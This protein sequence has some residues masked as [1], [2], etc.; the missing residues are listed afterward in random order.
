MLN[1]KTGII[2]ATLSLLV[3]HAVL[4][5]KKPPA[6]PPAGGAEPGSDI[7]LERVPFMSPEQ[8]MANTE[9]MKGFRL[10]LVAAEPQVIDPVAM[11]FDEA[12]RLFVVEMIDY[13]EQ[14]K[15]RL[16]R[17]RL[18]SDEDGDGR[19]EI[20]KIFVEDL[21]WPTAIACYD[22]GIFIGDAPDIL[23]C[24]D[25]DGDG[26]AD[27]RKV[28]FTGFGRTNVQGLLNTFLWGLDHK[29]YGQTSGSGGKVTRPGDKSP[30]LDL[31]DR[32]FCFDPKTLEI[33]AITGGG[34]HGMSFNRWGDR[35]VCQNSDHLQAIVFEERYMARNPYQSVVAARRSIATDGPQAP[36]F[37]IS[38]VEAWRIARTNLRV[39]GL[40]PGPIEGGGRAAGYF[41]GSTGV[42]VYEG[43]LWPNNDDA[44]VLISDVGSN[45]IHRKRLSRDG[46]TYRGDRIDEGAEFIR[47]RD[48]WFRPVQ[49]A[50]GPDGG[51]YVADMYREVIEHPA[52]L[53][54]VLKRQ[55]DLSSAGKGRLYRVVPADYKYTPPKLLSRASTAELAAALD[56]A[57]QWRRMTALRLIYEQQ[58]PDAGKLLHAQLAETKRPEG[59][60]AVLYA[61]DSVDSLDDADLL[62]ALGDAHP[63]VRRQAIQLSE[64]RLDESAPLREKVPSL[65]ADT[66]PA[67]QFQLAFSLGECHDN[68]ASAALASILIRSAANRDITDAVLTSIVDRAG[69]VMALA[70][71]NEKWAASPGGES[72][73]G[74]IVGQ[75]ARQRRAEDLD[76]LVSLLQKSGERSHAASQ[77]ALLK[78]LSRLP[79]DALNGSDPPQLT[80]LRE[81]RQSAAEKLIS[82]AEQILKQ[83]D[84]SLEDRVAAIEDLSLDKFDGQRQLLEELLSPQEPAAI[85]AAVLATCAQF[86]SPEVAPLVLSQWA[87]FAPSERS[88]ATDLL[89]RRGAWALAL[90]QH[91]QKENVKITTLDPAHAAKL[92]NYPSAKV[93][94][95]VRKLR[96]QGPPEDRQ[97]VFKDYQEVITAKGDAADGK[98]VFQKNCA[99]C[100]EIGGM[101]SAV[102]PNLAAMLSRG[103]ESVLFNVLA[104]NIEVDPRFLEYVV[105]TGDGQV[106]TGVIAGQTS[107]AV[108]IRGADN[109][110]T[111]VLRVDID[112]ISNTGKSLMPEGFEKVI[113][114]K[115][116]ANLLTFLQ[117]AA[118]MQGAGK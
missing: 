62:K 23:Y 100:H 90:A 92:D 31:H 116:M 78:A 38:P 69:M 54:A 111:T 40:V 67:V 47:S 76:A 70:L 114:K 33:S 88:Q 115:S 79:A 45:L 18:L 94:E 95:I 104:P 15:E 9:V 68:A 32:D 91:L 49:M 98:L 118:V 27:V 102:G 105:L 85:H 50:I 19:F 48:I 77:A 3:C 37:R 52:S 113:D 7:K 24:K 103:A 108:T 36:V 82:H 101:G 89:L 26:K 30:P 99:S 60:I 61:L 13:S 1:R 12:G 87:H 51:L 39:A 42:T 106:I 84:A 65:V 97:K 53:P 71:G 107:T 4:G 109:K 57:N 64:S 86:D 58:A 96:G 11:A 20:S 75:I 34:Q 35:F 66:D 41:T 72:V 110:T 17:I 80:V 5:A 16:G 21:S 81:L 25:E 59:R 56:D 55:L 73:L 6:K 8:E 44:T 22:G 117:Q 10:D 2:F 29:I 83:Q 46:V 43:G 93:R 74:S 63:Q 14:D 28:V 112:D